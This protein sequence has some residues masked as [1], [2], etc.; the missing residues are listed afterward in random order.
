MNFELVKFNHLCIHLFPTKP[1]V[2]LNLWGSST[3]FASVCSRSWVPIRMPS[4]PVRSHV[5]PGAPETHFKGVRHFDALLPK[6]KELV[7]HCEHHEGDG[8]EGTVSTFVVRT[9]LN[10]LARFSCLLCLE[11][12]V[13]VH[14]RINNLMNLVAVRSS[15]LPAW[16]LSCPWSY[17]QSLVFYNM[18][19]DPSDGGTIVLKGLMEVYD[20]TTHTYV[21]NFQGDPR[22]SFMTFTVK[23]LPGPSADTSTLTWFSDYT[24]VSDDMPPPDNLMDVVRDLFENFAGHAEVHFAEQAKAVTIWFP[25]LIWSCSVWNEKCSTT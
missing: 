20:V 11:V 15:L 16:I 3:G 4:T 19:A 25:T 12:L 9:C 10:L 7:S 21:I 1:S 6:A 18:I 2:S 13:L 14:H 23:F 22:Y 5:V 8:G 24:P 17:A